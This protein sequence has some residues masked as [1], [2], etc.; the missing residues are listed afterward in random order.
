[1]KRL[2]SA[3]LTAISCLC[4]VTP[5][6]AQSYDGRGGF[7]ISGEAGMTY[8]NVECGTV[9][10]SDAFMAP[11][12]IVQIGGSPSEQV[13]IALEVSY[14]RIAADTTARDYGVGMAVIRYYPLTDS[15]LF[16][17]LGAG[18]G[19][20]GEERIEED[21]SRWALSGSG[22]AIQAGAG[23]E[24]PL[25]SGIRF[26]PALSYVAALSH[27]AKRNRL[28]T[29]DVTGKFLRLGLQVTWQ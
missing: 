3:S 8:S 14:W 24:F 20:Y 12:G 19:R 15:P 5:A 1:M 13:M 10:F 11:M 29:F 22:F 27:K 2:M 23:Y 25:T 6:L 7:W 26:G 21:G 17:K 28:P 4:L 9:C 16:V 18:V